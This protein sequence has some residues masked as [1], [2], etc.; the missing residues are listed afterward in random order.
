MFPNSQDA[1]KLQRDHPISQLT[2]NPLDPMTTPMNNEK[3]FPVWQSPF[4]YVSDKLIPVE[5]KEHLVR[6][7]QEP[8]TYLNPTWRKKVGYA[9]WGRV[10]YAIPGI[11]LFRREKSK[12]KPIHERKIVEAILITDMKHDLFSPNIVRF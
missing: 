3:S 7:C 9:G 2:K 4:F 1:E 11:P 8:M 10:A 12:T 6:L 5:V